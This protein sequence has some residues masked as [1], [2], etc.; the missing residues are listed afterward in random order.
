MGCIRHN[1]REMTTPIDKG[2]SQLAPDALL[3]AIGARLAKTRIDR[4]LT[5]AELAREAGVSKRTVERIEAGG[6]VQVQN[7]FAVLRALDLLDALGAAIP[8]LGPN[9]LDLMRLSRPRE[10]V[11]HRESADGDWRWGDER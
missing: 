4:R 5:Q 6:S 11:R 8:E 7:F 1:S 2:L 9:P 3:A 10:R